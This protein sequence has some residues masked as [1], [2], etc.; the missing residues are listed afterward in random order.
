V[1]CYPSGIES[2]GGWFDHGSEPPGGRQVKAPG[3]RAICLHRG[4]E[5]SC[6]SAVFVDDH[7]FAGAGERERE[8]AVSGFRALREHAVDL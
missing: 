1:D 8:V 3:L 5:G 4:L 7:G 6:P 2:G